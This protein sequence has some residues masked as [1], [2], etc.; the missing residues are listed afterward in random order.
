MAKT[1]LITGSSRGLGLEFVRQL[2]NKGE[3]V[4]ATARNLSSATELM[5]LVDNKSVFAVAL[6]TTC[7][8]SVKAAVEEI[9]RI[10]PT[11]IDV[12]I[13]N[14][15]IAGATDAT[16][17]NTDK[18]DF[19]KV[20]ETNVVGTSNVSQA[21]LDLLRKKDTRII[22]NISSVLGSI[23]LNPGQGH[24]TAYSVSKAAENML[25]RSFAN[26]LKNESF[27]VVSV[28]PGWVRTD[29][30]GSQGH[31]SPSE[32]ITGMIEQLYKLQRSQNGT[33]FDY[34]GDALPW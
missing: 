14:S 16:F 27:I 32:S 6:D 15:G 13:N 23:E 31:L 11:G 9:G 26:G 7:M 30:G 20:F 21:T 5:A 1:V 34:K 3:I 33:F 29:M 24:K 19:M 10:A 4:I 12:L 28:H 17:L 22:F 8:D 25:T 18:D 2:I